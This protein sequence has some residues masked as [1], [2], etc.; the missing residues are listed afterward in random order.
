MKRTRGEPVAEPRPLQKA[1]GISA[2]KNARIFASMK[3][4]W[5]RLP[6]VSDSG[7]LIDEDRNR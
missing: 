1:R 2:A 3:P 6:L 4:I 5:K 7:K